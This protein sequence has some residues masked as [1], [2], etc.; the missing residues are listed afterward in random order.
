MA[1]SGPNPALAP[2]RRWVLHS[3]LNLTI[4]VVGVMLALFA[5]GQFFDSPADQRVVRTTADSV[6]AY[7]ASPT[8][9]GSDPDG[10][11]EEVNESQVSVMSATSTSRSA[12]ATAMA[13]AMTF[14][15]ITSDDESWAADVIAYSAES[16]SPTLIGARPRTPVSITG[17]TSSQTLDVGSEGGRQVRSI[18]PTAAGN[19]SITVTDGGID[20]PNWV[21]QTPLPTLDLDAVAALPP[22]PEENG[23]ST[24]AVEEFSTSAPTPTST[25]PAPAPAPTPTQLEIPTRSEDRSVTTPP[26]PVPVPGP[27]PIPDLDTP[28][29]GAL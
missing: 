14:V 24:D 19:L 1:G 18:V 22:V 25:T 20:D 12:P 5:V 28:L 26:A 8:T 11:L 3:R 10:E 23:T 27:I 15:D 4:T 6:T 29:P 9:R 17:P 13:Y 2:I 21:V 7:S 16:A